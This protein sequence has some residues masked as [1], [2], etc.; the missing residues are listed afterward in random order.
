MKFMR[1]L[2]ILFFPLT[3]GAQSLSGVV[4]QH[5]ESSLK[6]KVVVVRDFK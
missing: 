3:L 2:A 4:V 5:L 6:L 1:F